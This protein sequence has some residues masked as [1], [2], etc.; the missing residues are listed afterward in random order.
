MFLESIA[1]VVVSLRVVGPNHP[2]THYNLG[3][4]L[5][6]Q[7][8]LDAAIASYNKALQLNPNHPDAHNNLGNSLKEKG[9]LDAAIASYNML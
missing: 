1:K 6:E 4:T 7:G 3:N 5:Q 8:D 9:N 2:E